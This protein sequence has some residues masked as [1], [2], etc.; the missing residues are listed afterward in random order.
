MT[1]VPQFISLKKPVKDVAEFAE[2]IERKFGDQC[3][4]I[5]KAVA[6]IGL[7]AREFV[8]VFHEGAS[9]YVRHSRR[10]HDLLAEAGYRLPILPILRV[11]YQAWDALSAT[12]VWFRLPEP[13]RRPFGT[14]ELCSPSFAGRWR[15]VCHEQRALLATLA[16]LRRPIELI[17]FLDGH[18]RGAWSRLS[19]EYAEL[20]Q[21][22]DKVKRDVSTMQ[23]ERQGLYDQKRSLKSM[24]VQQE[25]D[26]G[27]HWRAELFEKEDVGSPRYT[28]EMEKRSLM[29]SEIEST[30]QQLRELALAMEQLKRK[31]AELVSSDMV[32]QVHARRR[33]I[34]LEAELRRMGMIREAV[35]SS[36]GLENANFR[37]AAWWMPVV[38]PDG[39]WFRETM[40]TAEA[41]L[42]PLISPEPLHA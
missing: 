37:P 39:S 3:T 17:E 41:Y 26:L 18:D 6:L 8:F 30:R 42:E 40:R 32:S 11:K 23:L 12:C 24:L 25:R 13:L 38:S 22:M 2:L 29:K 1:S 20:R 36:R 4:V 33:Q 5:G 15:E 21:K 28:R 31:Q 35:I 27:V 14:D 19:S 10:M 7:L 16:K 9:G 34:E